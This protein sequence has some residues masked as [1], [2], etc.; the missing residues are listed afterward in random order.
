VV[1]DG[2]LL[3]STVPVSIKGI[4]AP[5]DR[6]VIHSLDVRTGKDVWTFDTVEGDL[7]GHPEVNSGGGAW[8]PPA[9]DPERGVAYFGIANP[10]PFPGAPGWPNGTSRPGANLY[11]DSIVALDLDTGA[12]RWHVQVVPHDLLDRDQVMAMIA[13]TDDGPVAISSGKSGIASASIRPP[14]RSGGAPRSGATR[15][16]SSRSSRGRRRC[17]PAPMAACSPRR[18]RLTGSSTSR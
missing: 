9:I 3:V 15:T 14:G 8:Y 13:R 7:W 1:H 17:T 5:G 11:T 6:G 12:L 16:T 4:Y 18:P 2:R 10:A